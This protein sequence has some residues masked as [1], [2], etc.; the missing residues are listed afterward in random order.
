MWYLVSSIEQLGGNSGLNDVLENIAA[1]F[2]VADGLGMLRGDHDRVYALWLALG[3]VL[4]R[5]LRLAIRPQVRQFAVLAHWLR[6]SCTSLCASEIGIG[7]SS[8]VL[9][10]GIAKHHSLVAGAAG[11]YAHGDVA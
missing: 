3:V 5:D 11:V 10:A 9:I 8:A 7:I 2:V 6:A 1:Q 4:H